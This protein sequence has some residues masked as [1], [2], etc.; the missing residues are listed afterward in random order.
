MAVLSVCGLA[1][2]TGGDSAAPPT[3]PD[4]TSAAPSPSE[5]PSPTPTPDAATPPERP[6]MSTFDTQTAEAVALYFLQLFP[7]VYATGDLSDWNF[8]SH[9]EC[10]HCTSVRTGVEEMFAQGNHSEGGLFTIGDV[11]TAQVSS[12]WWHVTI[13]MLQKPSTTVDAAG[14]VVEE[15]P[16]QKQFQVDIA[17]IDAG[18][19]WLIREVEH[20]ERS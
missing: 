6:D 4:T 11:S 15:F 20:S 16:G 19:Q 1:A 14:S 10:I 2:C 7:Y 12:D 5:T 3:T 18:G 13:E 17:I 9:P 8:L